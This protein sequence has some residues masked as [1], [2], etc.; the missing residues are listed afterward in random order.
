MKKLLLLSCILL[1]AF[2]SCDDDNYTAKSRTQYLTTGK[3]Y[4]EHAMV[5]TTV[6]GQTYTENL[7]D[8]VPC[9]TKDNAITFRENGDIYM[10]E[11]VRVCEDNPMNGVVGKW[12]LVE[13][14]HVFRG[15]LPGIPVNIDL[16]VLDLDGKYLKLQWNGEREGIPATFNILYSHMF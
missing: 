16:Q 10:D 9:C 15:T 5:S 3:W 1:A 13:N 11:N 4:L 7:V 8:F 14:S 2:S 12:Q 6:E